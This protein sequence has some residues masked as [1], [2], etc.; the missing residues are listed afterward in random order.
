MD[1]PEWVE[2]STRLYILQ[3]T[4]STKGYRHRAISRVIVHITHDK[5]LH[6]GVVLQ[7]RVFHLT[8]LATAFLAIEATCK[9]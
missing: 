3:L 9:A 6:I 8:N 7:Q 2:E 1:I 4:L 5:N